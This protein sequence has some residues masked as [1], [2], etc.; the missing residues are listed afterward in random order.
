M[1]NIALPES[2]TVS[3]GSA[4]L[5]R[6]ETQ[7]FIPRI[8]G[9]PPSTRLAECMIKLDLRYSE[10]SLPITGPSGLGAIGMH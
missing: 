2:Q 5:F 4:F 1:L 7:K 8:P 9:P 6:N 10:E 3:H